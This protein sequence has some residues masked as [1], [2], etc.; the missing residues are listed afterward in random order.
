M[1]LLDVCEISHRCDPIS[2]RSTLAVRTLIYT[3]IGH[4]SLTQ[5]HHS[6]KRR[7]IMA[8]L[9]YG[10]HVVRSEARSRFKET[11]KFVRVRIRKPF[12]IQLGY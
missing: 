5:I 8:R 1:L 7:A 6:Y 3:P 4:A 9:L 11:W 12:H 10:C 2:R